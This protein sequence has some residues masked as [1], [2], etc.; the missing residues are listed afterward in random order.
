M[1]FQVDSLQANQK[2]KILGYR[3]LRPQYS[4][5]LTV[6]DDESQY[7]CL[8]ADLNNLA[9]NGNIHALHGYVTTLN[10]KRASV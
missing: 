9:L 10:L 6:I 2:G 7:R 1:T 8:R 3:A 4:L 5:N